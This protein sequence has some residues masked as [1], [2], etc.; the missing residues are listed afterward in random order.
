MSL[1]AGNRHAWFRLAS[2]YYQQCR[3][4]SWR[5]SGTSMAPMLDRRR[6]ALARP[7]SRSF[8]LSTSLAKQST[9]QIIRRKLVEEPA[10]APT[11][12]S[13]L[14]PSK[15]DHM[16]TPLGFPPVAPVDHVGQAQKTFVVPYWRPE[17]SLESYVASLPMMKL[18]Q[19][20]A[21]VTTKSVSVTN[22]LLKSM[23]REASVFGLDMEWQPTFVKNAKQ[24]K[25]A[26]I[27]ICNDH[28]VLLIQIGQMKEFPEELLRF[29]QSRTLY[30]TGVNIT[31]DGNKLLRD[32]GIC[33]NGLVDLGKMASKMDTPSLH[34][35][36]RFRSL[37]NLTALFLGK[38]LPKDKGVRLSNWNAPFL[39]KYQI[40]YAAND[41]YAS[42]ALYQ[43]L[44][45]VT[46]KQKLPL[47][48]VNIA[49]HAQKDRI[50]EEPVE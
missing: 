6:L 24:K 39:N 35:I 7:S 30:K 4:G 31:G 43:A 21:I 34:R 15:S 13:T 37:D 10:T 36:G 50:E 8:T 16:Q 12:A 33:T 45:K 14:I 26:L 42:Y 41:A 17:L 38:R 32:F 18:P 23:S 46:L 25:T 3:P 20:Y 49:D 2:Y 29:L 47:S 48:V 22:N 1:T 40:H 5:S 11:K 19:E 27:Q 9:V 44:S 28:K